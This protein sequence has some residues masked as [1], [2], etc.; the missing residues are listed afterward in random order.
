MPSRADFDAWKQDYKD[1]QQ[2]LIAAIEDLRQ[3]N[4]QGVEL[5]DQ[6][7]QDLIQETQSAHQELGDPPTPPNP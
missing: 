5:T 7:F 6:D 2:R 4:A 3:K 1:T